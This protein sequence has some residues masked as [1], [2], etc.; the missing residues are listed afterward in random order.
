MRTQRHAPARTPQP[1]DLASYLQKMRDQERADL[2]RELHDELGALLTCAKLDIA[3]LKARL[4]GSSSDIDQRL[5]HL[6]DTL[7]SGIA[8]SRRVV[9]GLHPS[10]LTNLGLKESLEILSHDF[11][12]STGVRMATVLNEVEGMDPATELTVY[13]IVQEA[14]NNSAK[15]AGA[16]KAW[17]T[18]LDGETDLVV[19]VRDDGKGFDAAAMGTSSHGLAGM[20]HR[21]ESCGGTLHVKSE[22]G[23]GTCVVA[24]LPVHA[25]THAGVA[26]SEADH[27]PCPSPTRPSQMRASYA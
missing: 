1:V 25:G 21:A 11:E 3:G 24:V 22:P 13:R 2:A 15:H 10:S 6:S 9:E 8:F 5:Q 7:N 12:Q 19:S 20:R 27:P 18:M 16:G 14:L 4:A 17:V 23:R 26:Y